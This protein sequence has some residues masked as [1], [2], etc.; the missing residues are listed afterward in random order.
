MRLRKGTY[1]YLSLRIVPF[2]LVVML[3]I[4]SCSNEDQVMDQMN[5][6]NQS[7]TPQIRSITPSDCDKKDGIIEI[8][9]LTDVT[10]SID[11]V[12]FQ[13]EGVFTDLS[14]GSYIVTARSGDCLSTTE[15]IIPSDISLTDMI[16]PILNSSCAIS[17][18]HV[19][20]EQSPDLSIRSNILSA[21]Q[22]IISNISSGVMPPANS[23][24]PDLTEEDIAYI[25][26]WV[27]SGSADN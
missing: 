13:I 14:P 23:S 11:G 7:I 9:T 3:A 2:S 8:S 20:G 25:R 16:V 27:E 5:C 12:N 10:Y 22:R 4:A 17:G 15:A 26:C 6:T 1:R 24:G 21:S 18:C 19:T